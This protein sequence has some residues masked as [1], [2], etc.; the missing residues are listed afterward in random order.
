MHKKKTLL[1]E[2]LN[3]ALKKLNEGNFKD[4]E[5]IYK[6]I[7][8]T[9]PN[10]AGTLNNLGTIYTFLEEYEKAKTYFEK[11]IEHNP[12]DSSAH[13]NL[14]I[15]FKKLKDNI[16]AKHCFEKALKLKLIESPEEG[17]FVYNEMSHRGF[18]L[19]SNLEQIK[20]GNKQL[21]LLTWP[22]LDFI[23]TLNLKNI[24][25]HEIGSGNSTI[26]FSNIFDKV[27]SYETNQEWYEN[28]KPKL[29]PNVSLKLTKLENIYN[30]SIKFKTEDW[31]LI[32]FAG[33]R[34]KFVNNLVK[35]SDN[36][37]PAQ[38]IFDNSEWYRNGAKILIDRGYVEIPFYGFKSGEQGIYCSSLFLLKEKFQIKTLAQFYYPKFSSKLQHDWDA[39]D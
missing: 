22:L 13:A 3:L 4:A 31:L 32:D 23:K 17:L 36:K 5:S 8:K 24:T 20:K 29:K 18:F 11:A 16:K 30:C 19:D 38:I 34:T 21:P 9:E 1:K 15:I 37:V 25:L 2:T 12:N 10:H 14:G 7:L 39:K 26:W 35:F 6:E 28:L 33:K 27:E